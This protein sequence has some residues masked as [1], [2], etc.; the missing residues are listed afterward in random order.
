MLVSMDTSAGAKVLCFRGCSQGAERAG[1]ITDMN[2]QREESDKNSSPDTTELPDS[3]KRLFS[4]VTRSCGF[5]VSVARSRFRV[6]GWLHCSD[7][8]PDCVKSVTASRHSDEVADCLQFCGVVISKYR[9][10]YGDSW[11]RGQ[12]CEGKYWSSLAITHPVTSS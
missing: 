3:E 11:I 1:M 12:R 7:I 2:V 8:S 5:L 9:P 6:Q 4:A 10:R